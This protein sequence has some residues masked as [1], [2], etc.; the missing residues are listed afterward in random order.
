MVFFWL[1]IRLFHETYFLESGLS[2]QDSFQRYHKAVSIDPCHYS[3]FMNWKTSPEYPP[4]EESETQK[5]VYCSYCDNFGLDKF[6]N[7]LNYILVD[8][9]WSKI[10]VFQINSYDPE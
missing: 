5:C 8:S 6:L 1:F 3:S 7:I 10:I 2:G 4:K 9:F